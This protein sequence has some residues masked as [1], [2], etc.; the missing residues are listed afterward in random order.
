M[1]SDFNKVEWQECRASVGRFDSILSDLRRYG[2]TL[3]TGVLSAQAVLTSTLKELPDPA[4]ALV[5]SSLIFLVV[6]AFLLD[7]YYQVLLWAAIQRAMRLEEKLTINDGDELITQFINDKAMRTKVDLYVNRLYC[8]FIGVALLL[9]L[10][11]IQT[12]LAQLVVPGAAAL[13]IRWITAHYDGTNSISRTDGED[14]L[15]RRLPTRKPTPKT[16]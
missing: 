8:L 6:G 7:R 13:S 5:F 2:F 10:A 15:P 11:I 14:L 16:N 1:A 3:I 4:R 9:S 12:L